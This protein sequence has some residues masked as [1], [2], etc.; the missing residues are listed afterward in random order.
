MQIIDTKHPFYKPLWRRLAIVGSIAFWLAF[1]VLFGGDPMWMMISLALLAYTA[2]VL[3]L[4]WPR[5]PPA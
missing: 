1:E 4:A 5:T 3:L 2:W